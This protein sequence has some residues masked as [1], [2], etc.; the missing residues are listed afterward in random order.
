MD[1]TDY[2]KGLERTIETKVAELEKMQQRNVKFQKQQG[3]K[4][5]IFRLQR[6]LINAKKNGRLL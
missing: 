4:E 3:V 6:M 2:I 5:E 1:N